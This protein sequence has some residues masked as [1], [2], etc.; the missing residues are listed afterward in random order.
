MFRKFRRRMP[1][2]AYFVS[3]LVVA[4]FMRAVLAQEATPTPHDHSVD[5]THLPLGDGKYTT[6]PEVGSVFSCMTNYVEAGMAGAFREGPWFNGDGTFNLTTKAIVDGSV[7]WNNQF[8]IALNGATRDFTTNILPDHPTGTYPVDANDD[9]YQYDRNPN[10]ISEQS[11]TFSLPANPTLAVSPNCVG[12]EI[13]ILLSGV[14]LFNAF[15]AGGR[16]ALAHETQDACDG[17]PQQSGVYHYHNL[18][19]CVEDEG[20]GHSNLV[21]YAWDGFGIFG[22][23]GEDGGIMTNA[24][25]D[26]CHGHTHLIEWDGQQVEMYHYHATYEF[27]YVIGCFRGNAE[28]VTAGGGGEGG[29]PP[30]GGQG[31]QG[32]PPTGGQGGN[33]PPPPPG[34]AGG[35]PPPP[36]PGRP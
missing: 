9:A 34:G 18:S 23:R 22:L 27:P 21:G 29:M 12:G 2:P 26:E 13:G 6:A 7:T 20:T 16:D 17:H 11:L 14:V 31:G 25:L 33:P 4:F 3:V 24:D 10:S 8:T 1:H 28:R 15:D 5:L 19:D 35:N 32:T 36:P 30:Q